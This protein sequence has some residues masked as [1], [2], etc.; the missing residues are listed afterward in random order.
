LKPQIESP[1]LISSV[2]RLLALLLVSLFL[3]DR[4]RAQ[5]PGFG[6][7]VTLGHIQGTARMMPHLNAGIY[8]QWRSHQV[9]VR[10]WGASRCR[11]LG[12]S[13][14]G[15]VARGLLYGHVIAHQGGGTALEIGM[16]QLDERWSTATGVGVQRGM[17]VPVGIALWQN[18]GAEVGLTFRVNAFARTTG[19]V[20]VGYGIGVHL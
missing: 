11:P 6:A 17:T 3:S 10:I 16:A 19:R 7:D 4:S 20:L 13:P 1:L 8:G 5:P 14:D 15:I 18:L 12:C 2:M 9:Q